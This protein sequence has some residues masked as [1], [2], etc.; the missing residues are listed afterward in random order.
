[1]RFFYE[2][3]LTHCFK[4]E[5]T[6]CVTEKLFGAPPW[7]FQGKPSV[8][9]CSLLEGVHMITSLIRSLTVCSFSTLLV[10]ASANAADFGAYGSAPPSLDYPATS[11]GASDRDLRAE[12]TLDVKKNTWM[13]E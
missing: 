8:V 4:R 13:Q 11:F 1:M 12:A 7:R 10:L 9:H 5:Y 6:Q 2:N 3:Y